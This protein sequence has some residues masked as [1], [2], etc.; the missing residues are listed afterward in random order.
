MKKRYAFEY[1]PQRNIEIFKKS[2]HRK[3]YI[4]IHKY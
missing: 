1:T 4:S 2:L 3:V